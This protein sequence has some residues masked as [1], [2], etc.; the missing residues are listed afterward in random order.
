MIV[1]QGNTKLKP[2][3]DTTTAKKATPFLIYAKYRGV[4]KCGRGFLAGEQIE[5]DPIARDKRCI[6]CINKRQSSSKE[7]GRVIQFDSYRGVVQRLRQ[8]DKLP[9]PL[10]KDVA[11]EYYKLMS[12]IS[13]ATEASK[14]V[15]DYLQSSARCCKSSDERFVVTLVE[16]KACVHCS[17]ILRKGELVLMEFPSRSAHCIWCEC[18]HL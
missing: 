17:E 8:I 10:A 3:K 11:A 18:T 1:Q 9:R 15:K 5:F 13:T 2:R 14:S 12:E 4:C 7:F 6:R 16:D